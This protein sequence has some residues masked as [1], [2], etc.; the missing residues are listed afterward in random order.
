MLKVLIRFISL[1]KIPNVLVRNIIFLAFKAILISLATKSAL[2]LNPEYL[3][4][5][6]PETEDIIGINPSSITLLR[7]SGLIFLILPV[8]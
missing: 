3:S 2:T 4:S 5:I 1:S 8:Y 7:I 6:E